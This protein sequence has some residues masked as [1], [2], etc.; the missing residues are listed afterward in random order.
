MELFRALALLAEP[1]TKE[2]ERVAEALELGPLPCESEHTEIFLFQL[3]PYAS[4]YLGAEG[5]IGGEARDLIAGFWRALSRTPPREPDHLALMLALY[6]S[7]CGVEEDESDAL[8]R[9]GL[10]NARKAFLWEHLLSWLPVYL[11]KLN[12]IA[13]PFYRKWG[14]M[15]FQAL[16]EESKVVG[17]QERLSLHLREA[18]QVVDPREEGIEKF[19]QSLLTP[20]RS[21]IILTRADLQ[22]AARALSLGS[23]MGERL[24]I[25]KALFGQDAGAMLLWLARE[26]SNWT[27]LHRKRAKVFGETAKV[28]KEK[29]KATTKLLK[30]LAASRLI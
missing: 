19:L 24:F 14:E 6:A 9:S 20:A 21:G 11:D 10:R 16:A 18:E 17:R 26:T 1:P 4:V 29:S 30:Q 8:R 15:L 12:E 23:R 3:Y 5:M 28:W 13:T 22:R 27:A 2:T 25:L 7:L